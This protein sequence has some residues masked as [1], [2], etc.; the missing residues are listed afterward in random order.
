MD[1]LIIH[2]DEKEIKEF[3]NTYVR[4]PFVTDMRCNVPGCGA[5]LF[6]TYQQYI[7][8]WNNVHIPNVT[9]LIC[10]ICGRNYR[11]RNGLVSHLKNYHCVTSQM[12]RYIRYHEKENALFIAPGEETFARRPT[13][14]ELKKQEIEKKK[15]EEAEKRRKLAIELG[16]KGR[17]PGEGVYNS[18]DFH[19]ELMVKDNMCQTV[20]RQKHTKRM[21]PYSAPKDFA[22]F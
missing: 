4:R 3:T 11:F 19:V 1:E 5:V 6:S 10:K 7:H 21:E 9:L 18:R 14:E 17:I 8:H 22:D 20:I 2:A 12:D 16:I 15:K 13:K